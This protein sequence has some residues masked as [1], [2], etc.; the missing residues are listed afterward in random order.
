MIGS[1]IWP[2]ES[3]ARLSASIPAVTCR[4]VTSGALTATI[5]GSG[6]PGNAACARL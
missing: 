1:C 5:A 6:L 3:A 2:V 4:A